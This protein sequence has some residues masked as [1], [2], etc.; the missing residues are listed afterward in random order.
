VY[1]SVIEIV[2]SARSNSHKLKVVK[3][4]LQLL[5]RL[6]VEALPHQEGQLVGVLAG[7]GHPHSPWPVVVQVGQLVGQLLQQE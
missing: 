7:G 5:A 4:L 2:N 3:N 6:P 1:N